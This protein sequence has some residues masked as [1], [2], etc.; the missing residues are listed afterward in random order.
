MSNKQYPLT[1]S[2]WNWEI[3]KQLN[4][5]NHPEDAYLEY[6]RE[7]EYDANAGVSK[8]EWGRELER[9]F[10]AFANSHGGIIL[11]GM[12]DSINPEG[13]EIPENEP[14]QQAYQY[15]QNTTPVVELD[16][17]GLIEHPHN[18]R[19]LLAIEVKEANTKPVA[20]SDSSYYIRTANG[21][22][23][24]PRE[25][26]QSLFV[27]EDRRQ[28]SVLHLL[29]EMDRFESAYQSNIE[30]EDKT[31]PPP[32]EMVDIDALR[33]SI[34]NCTHLYTQS[35][36]QSQIRYVLKC[37]RD[38]EQLERNY[39]RHKSRNAATPNTGKSWTDEN[40]WTRLIN[41]IENLLTYLEKLRSE[42]GIQHRYEDNFR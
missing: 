27:E 28:Q 36:V 32:F 40:V 9:E 16:S 41:S 34:R 29:I 10:T 24:M 20:T 37:L 35:G 33:D 5:L 7:L 38:I 8:K 39:G 42:A 15:I 6:K 12:S 3:I 19:G 13:F 31:G 30:N 25:H 17:S 14:T 11:F 2:E 21:K 22:S 18:R 4:E 26:I 1:A 23:P